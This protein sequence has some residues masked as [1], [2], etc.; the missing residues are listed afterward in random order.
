MEKEETNS[1]SSDRPTTK[2]VDVVPNAE[3]V[4][5]PEK[6]EGSTAEAVGAKPVEQV[7]GPTRRV[8]KKAPGTSSAEEEF[9]GAF[10]KGFK[11]IRKIG[12]ALNIKI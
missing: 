9:V 1:G 11:V 7:T 10:R 6:A 5:V 4:Y 2:I 8:R 12:E 3:G